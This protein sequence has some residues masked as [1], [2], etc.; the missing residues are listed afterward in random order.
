[1][2]ELINVF[3]LFA[4]EDGEEAMR[5]IA[6]VLPPIVGLI[7]VFVFARG[8]KRKRLI[9]DTPT[10]VVKG[11]FVGL[12]EVKGNADLIA[13]LRGYLSEQN[14]C[15]YSYTIEE[16]YTRT[17]TY[18]DSEGRTK[19]RTESGWETV[20]SGSNRVPFDL[21]D[22]TG[23]VRVIPTDAEMEGNIVFESRSTPGD[24]LYYEKGPAY[25]V[26]GSNY[27][28][29][30]KER[31]IVQDDLLYMLGSARIAE[32]AAKVEI[33]KED[34]IFMITVKSEEQL[35]SRYGWM[36]RGGWLGVVVGAALTPVSIGC[37]IGDRRYDDIWYWMIPAGVGG[38]VLTTLIYVIYVFNGLVSTK[39]RLARAWSLI[40]IQ[41]KRRYDLIGN[42]VGICKSYLKHEKETH[43]LVIAARSGKYTQG[44]AP[45]DQ[46][47][48][49]TDQVTT[50]QNQVI[51]QMFALREA[52]PKLKADTQ[53]IELHKHLT[54]CE[55]RLA[56][57]RTFYNE[58]AG[59]YNE[60][61]R[62]VP[63]VLFARMMGYIVAKYYEV[64]AEHTQP[65][66]VG[67]LLEK[68]KAAAGEPVIKAPEL[69]GEDEQ[70]VILALVCLMSADGNIDA[71][72][73]AAFEKFVADA[74]GSSDIGVARTKAQQALD[75]VKSGGLEA[76]E[77]SCLDRLPS[78]VGKDIVR[79]FLQALDDI[80]EATADGSW[81]EASMLERF[82]KAVS[83]AG[84]E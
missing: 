40:D 9:E 26:R 33:A 25:A 27:R 37:L 4:E 75:Q 35:V 72:E 49:S 51:N 63:E 60:R 69:I 23:A 24:G 18:T 10:S 53:L 30:F 36:V 7:C 59:N 2:Q 34:D 83:D 3:M 42:L 58:G 52:Y 74:T 28:R 6:G 80:A 68:E 43:Q 48:S 82:R 64:S 39:V 62:R 21:V 29:R 50:A 13:N 79:S 57:A 70:L 14:C 20:A 11:I 65:V 15:W 84:K 41:L 66:D 71:D 47:V 8:T 56:I 19:T 12:N 55:E 32:D 81:D 46:Q 17:T 5:I 44:E 38:L 76:A 45:T 61:I 16:H 31:A 73:Y 77:K 78:L 1:M 54:E 22:E 67:S